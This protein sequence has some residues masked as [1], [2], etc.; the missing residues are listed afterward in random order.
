MAESMMNH[1]NATHKAFTVVKGVPWT[2]TH[3][4]R[5]LSLWRTSISTDLKDN[6]FTVT[7]ILFTGVPYY[8]S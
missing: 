1:V 5:T 8:L 2:V 7:S 6:E 4:G 3:R